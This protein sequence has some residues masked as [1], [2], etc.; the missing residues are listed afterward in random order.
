MCIRDSIHAT[1]NISDDGNITIGDADT[2]NVVFNAEVASNIIPDLNN[3]YSLGSDPAT[4]GK[5]WADVWVNNLNASNVIADDIQVDGLDLTLRQGNIWYV[6]EN[7]DNTRSGDHIQAPVASLKY[8]L[9]NLATAGDTVFIFP[10]VYT[11]EFPLTVPR[12]VAVKGQ[13]IR[14][15]NI[16]PTTA[17]RYND[18]CLLYT[19]PSPRD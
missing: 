8:A 13:G 4:G 3:T 10:G 12:G 9:D 17:T 7:G 19:S 18:A 16:K 2:D 1:G 15:V 14:S 5:K 6:A 11:E